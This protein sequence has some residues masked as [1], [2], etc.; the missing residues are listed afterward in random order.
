LVGVGGD[1]PDHASRRF[2]APQ[3]GGAGERDLLLRQP[4]EDGEG[5]GMGAQYRIGELLEPGLGV[6]ALALL[7]QRSD[8]V[9][10]QRAAEMLVGEDVG[11]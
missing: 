5:D 4:V 3:Q 1:G 7:D 6:L 11:E 10:V 9:Q 8:P 2:E